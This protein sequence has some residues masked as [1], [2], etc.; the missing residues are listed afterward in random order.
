MVKA[1]PGIM[2]LDAGE[3]GATPEQHLAIAAHLMLDQGV[4]ICPHCKAFGP[5]GRFCG[6]CGEQLVDKAALHKCGGCGHHTDQ[7]F[8][9]LCGS[10]VRSETVERLERGETTLRA[11]VGKSMRLLA[12]WQDKKRRNGRR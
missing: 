8:C 2:G 5:A 3:D 12:E 7:R 6:S 11:E 4:D 10:R 1:I 9:E